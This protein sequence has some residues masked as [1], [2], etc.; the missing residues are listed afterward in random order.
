MH[1]PLTQQQKILLEAANAIEEFGHL[2]NSLGDRN[3]GMCIRG[4][5]WFAGGH[6]AGDAAMN[7]VEQ[8]LGLSWFE[9]IE[10]NNAP[11]RTAAEVIAALRET[12][13]S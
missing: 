5:L 8:K 3:Q 11:E 2:K 7:A 6:S 13:L 12:A 1:K 9:A 10:W 4:A